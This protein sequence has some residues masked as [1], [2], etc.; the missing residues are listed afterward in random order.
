MSD[1]EN[2]SESLEYI[3]EEEYAFPDPIEEDIRNRDSLA[4]MSADELRLH[5]LLC[6]EE[7]HKRR[8]EMALEAK[9]LEAATLLRIKEERAENEAYLLRHF[10]R[11]FMCLVHIVDQEA[12]C[13]YVKKW[14]N[15]PSEAARLEEV[16]RNNTFEKTLKYVGEGL[17]RASDQRKIF[18][19]DWYKV[20]NFDHSSGSSQ[21]TGGATTAFS[22]KYIQYNKAFE[23]KVGRHYAMRRRLPT[24]YAC[25]LLMAHVHLLSKCQENTLN[26]SREMKTLLHELYPPGLYEEALKEASECMRVLRLLCI[27]KDLF[28]VFQGTIIDLILEQFVLSCVPTEDDE[29]IRELSAL[30][31]FIEVPKTVYG[32]AKLAELE[33]AFCA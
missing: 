21:T 1:A 7:A 3:S 28:Y 15:R 17:E 2:E 31:P 8:Q 16:K 19:H 11:R 13:L 5:S 12:L 18:V 6:Q 20:P 10:S 30:K 32:R 4:R 29:L 24:I 25:Q 23:A 27:E 26:A 14:T 9:R 22:E 33:S